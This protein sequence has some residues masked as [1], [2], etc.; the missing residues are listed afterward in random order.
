M[1]PLWER[2][3]I[4]IALDLSVPVFILQTESLSRPV[5]QVSVENRTCSRPRAAKERPLRGAQKKETTMECLTCGRHLRRSNKTGYCSAHHRK[6]NRQCLELTKRSCLRCDRQFLAIGRLNRICP[7]C[8][9]TNK[10][11]VNASRY[12]IKLRNEWVSLG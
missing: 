8:H 3:G 4:L 1:T 12:Q 10:Q 7:T 5:D 11:I 2:D 6:K 9:E